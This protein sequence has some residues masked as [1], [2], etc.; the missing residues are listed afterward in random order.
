MPYS[1]FSSM[2]GSKSAYLRLGEELGRPGEFLCRGPHFLKPWHR[3]HHVQAQNTIPSQ[4]SHV[5][6]ENV[7]FRVIELDILRPYDGVG[8]R[9]VGR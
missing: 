9:I 2:L 3:R 1:V 4:Q 5:I 6:I 8:L 7:F